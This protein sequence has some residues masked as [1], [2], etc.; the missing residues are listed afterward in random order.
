MDS[1]S[2]FSDQRERAH[3][4]SG[5]SLWLEVL[6]RWVRMG[7]WRIR[8]ALPSSMPAGKLAGPGQAHV[9]HPWPRRAEPSP[10]PA[11]TA[12][13]R[14]NKPVIRCGASGRRPLQRRLARRRQET[15]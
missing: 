6:P 3:G 5:S 12:Q 7:R 13:G 9:A 4:S 14:C 15:S 11:A 10:G 2:R 1:E 8:V